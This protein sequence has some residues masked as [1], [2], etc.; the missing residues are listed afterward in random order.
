MNKGGLLGQMPLLRLRG[1]VKALIKHNNK[2]YSPEWEKPRATSTPWLLG[3]S[4]WWVLQ[5]TSNNRANQDQFV[6]Q[7]PPAWL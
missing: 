6:F 1:R 2:S 5:N 7:W 4:K 3:Y